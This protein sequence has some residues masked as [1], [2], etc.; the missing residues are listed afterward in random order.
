MFPKNLRNS[1][2]TDGKGA[3][4]GT[5]DNWIQLETEDK[6]HLFPAWN[7]AI[8][9]TRMSA[10]SMEKVPNGNHTEKPKTRSHAQSIVDFGFRKHP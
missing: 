5:D 7:N 3:Q 8:Y 1:P 6:N 2:K 10:G 9:V 4:S